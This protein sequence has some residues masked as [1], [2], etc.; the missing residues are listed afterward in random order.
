MAKDKTGMAEKVQTE[1]DFDALIKE[2][3]EAASKAAADL[4][5]LIAD[6]KEQEKRKFESNREAFATERNT[7]IERIKVLD[8]MFGEKSNLY[9]S[10]TNVDAFVENLTKEQKKVLQDKYEWVIPKSIKEL[11]PLIEEITERC[12]GLDKSDKG[13]AL[14]IETFEAKLV[15]NG[16]LRNGNKGGIS[17][18]VYDELAN[19]KVI[20]FTAKPGKT[21]QAQTIIENV[22]VG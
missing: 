18:K 21:P 1:L 15:R 13:V 20:T 19:R 2:A 22:I 14:P 11:E 5:K 3:K 10:D 9:P 8:G 4:E 17:R 12:Q 7:I 6:K 16:K